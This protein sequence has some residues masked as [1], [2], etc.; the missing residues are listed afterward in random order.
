MSVSLVT[1]PSH[2]FGI[3]MNEV[4]DDGS[5]CASMEEEEGNTLIRIYVKSS[6]KRDIL[7][8]VLWHI[9]PFVVSLRMV[10]NNYFCIT[11]FIQEC[12]RHCPRKV[13]FWTDMFSGNVQVDNF[14]SSICSQRKC[15]N[16]F[17]RS[18]LSKDV[19]FQQFKTTH[20]V[21]LK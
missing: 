7:L 12:Q 9:F 15:S 3:L 6:W 14:I 13:K 16:N 5:K 10:G 18:I 17:N 4:L 20:F 21:I 19:R 2:L 1:S 8:L 11:W